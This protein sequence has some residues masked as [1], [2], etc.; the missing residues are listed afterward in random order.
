MPKDDVKKMTFS[1]PIGSDMKRGFDTKKGD[2]EPIQ[3]AQGIPGSGRDI[4]KDIIGGKN[5][6]GVAQQGAAEA[7][8]VNPWAPRKGMD[9][10]EEA[11]WQ[12]D[13]ANLP[14]Y[15]RATDREPTSKVSGEL[16]RI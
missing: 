12:R 10:S 14:K 1:N 5:S 2:T 15:F 16:T 3:P 9:P 13:A 4:V 11:K 7:I 8:R 6:S